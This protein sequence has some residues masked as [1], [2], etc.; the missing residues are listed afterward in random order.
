MTMTPGSSSAAVR[1]PVTL[2]ASGSDLQGARNKRGEYVFACPFPPVDL[3]VTQAGNPRAYNF[4]EGRPRTGREESDTSGV[5]M[6]M[7]C[8]EGFEQWWVG[9][10]PKLS[11]YESDCGRVPL[12]GGGGTKVRVG[13]LRYSLAQMVVWRCPDLLCVSTPPFPCLSAADM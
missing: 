13:A 3:H 7:W 12:K 8:A 4:I 1:R 9:L 11:D 5:A 2:L 6:G 10:L